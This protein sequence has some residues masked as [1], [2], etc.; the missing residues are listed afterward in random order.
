MITF[1][2]RVLVQNQELYRF[3][4]SALG[5]SKVHPD[6]RAAVKFGVR[7][8]GE[9]VFPAEE[10]TVRTVTA[11]TVGIST[12][13]AFSLVPLPCPPGTVHARLCDAGIM[14]LAFQVSSC[15]LC[16]LGS[17]SASAILRGGIL[18]PVLRKTTS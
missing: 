4:P 12:S 5:L 10:I 16:L 13:A 2:S 1:H 18:W 3:T 11:G 8:D 17:V 15:K 6:S 14:V 9:S 7:R